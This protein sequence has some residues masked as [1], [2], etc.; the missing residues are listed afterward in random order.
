MA[1]SVW[2]EFEQEIRLVP[3]D[4]LR[5]MRAN[6]YTTFCMALGHN[7]SHMNE[8]RLSLI[9]IEFQDRGVRPPGDVEGEFNGVG[10]V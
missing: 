10:S 1:M 8:V 7:K 5:A 3:L 2:E 4:K 9:D 6:V